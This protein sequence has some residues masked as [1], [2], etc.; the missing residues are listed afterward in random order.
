MTTISKKVNISIVNNYLIMT[1]GVTDKQLKKFIAERMKASRAIM[2]WNQA[3]MAFQ[4]R[5]SPKSYCELEGGKI[6]KAAIRIFRLALITELS[7]DQ[8]FPLKSLS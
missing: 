2:G 7:L 8:L 5:I 6:P 4:L 3:Q 1:I